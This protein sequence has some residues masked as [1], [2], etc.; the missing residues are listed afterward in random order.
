MS[1]ML[2]CCTFV[3]S[4]TVVPL[5]L[6][7][8]RVHGFQCPEFRIVERFPSCSMHCVEGV[9]FPV[10]MFHLN[11]HANNVWRNRKTFLKWYSAVLILAWEDFPHVLV[12]HRHMFWST[13][14][15][16]G[17]YPFHPQHVH[18]LLPG[19]SAVRLEFCH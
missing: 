11:K 9:C 1:N 17:L 6:L 19:D 16:D 4:A 13:L 7:K 18:S 12:F 2:I 8:N 14:H 15:D 3:T 10:L 5:L